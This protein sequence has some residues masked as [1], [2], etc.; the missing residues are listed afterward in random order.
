MKNNDEEQR[1]VRRYLL[2]DLTAEEQEQLE[3]HFMTNS[4]YR[5]KVLL[6]EE[7][8]IQDYL[9]HKLSDEERERFD[10]HFLST[11]Q[12]IQKLGIAKALNQ[13]FSV[14]AAAHSPPLSGEPQHADAKP[15]RVGFFRLRNPLL[16]FSL[17]ALLL[18][19]LG[20]SWVLI[21]RWRGPDQLVAEQDRE[22]QKELARLNSSPSSGNE[23]PSNPELPRAEALTLTLPPV[24]FRGG[25][26][27]PV[28]VLPAPAAIV[29]LW[30]V[31]PA[32]EH[33][34]Y[35]VVLQK[36]GDNHSYTVDDL[37]AMSTE[38]GKAVSLKIPAKYLSRGDYLLELSGL[39]ANSYL[40]PVSS[41]SFR[42]L[43]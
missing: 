9:A 23:S 17:A 19:V 24:T 38:S 6:I 30:L 35:R 4:E 10:E 34:S 13:Y 36:S 28:V 7:E 37:A 21:D 11:P 5:E 27:L 40:E 39:N 42:V 33:Q 2:G 43:N 25:E 3:E 18:I 16:A 26:Q 12:Q 14:E 22:F 29:Q 31:L 32:G 41:Y 20:G 15:G 8:L 1:L